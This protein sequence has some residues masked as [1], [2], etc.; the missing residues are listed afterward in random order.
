MGRY[1]LIASD[2]TN[3]KIIKVKELNS[4]TGKYEYKEKV[5]L[6]TIDKYTLT[7]FNSEEQLLY[8]LKASGI[9]DN[10]MN[11]LYI[12]YNIDGIK[13]TRIVYDENLYGGINSK[14][15]EVFNKKNKLLEVASH[16]D[17]KVNMDQYRFNVEIDRLLTN[18]KSDRNYY[19]YLVTTKAIN[20]HTI[21]YIA[22][23]CYNPDKK[24]RYN[25]DLLFLYHKILSNMS[26]YKMFR[27]YM[28]ATKDYYEENLPK[29]YI[30]R[31]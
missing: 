29:Q 31:S 17:S 1:S 26:N 16:S 15:R 8:Y 13:M 27:D 4:K 18:C 2:G 19:D 24:I 10:N 23:Y 12:S 30:H 14:D 5:H 3:N 6:S 25:N 21:E 20:E 11:K 28:V 7:Y 22:E 9:I